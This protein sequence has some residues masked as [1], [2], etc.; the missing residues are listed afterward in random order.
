MAASSV[1]AK[2]TPEV[3][4]RSL[5]ERFDAKDQKLIRATE[6]P[7]DGILSIAARP[8]GVRLYLMQGP[9]RSS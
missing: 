8:D 3:R 6:H 9:R 5:I 7:T 1:D 2:G 4:L